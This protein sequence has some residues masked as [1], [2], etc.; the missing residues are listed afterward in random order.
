[1]AYC[2]NPN[3]PEPQNPLVANFCQACGT[4]L[5]LLD[6]HNTNRYQ[7]ISLLGQGGFG[8]TFLAERLSSDTNRATS[9]CT[10][11]Q[12]YNNSLAGEADFQTEAERLRKLGEHLQIPALLTAVENELGQ[13]LVQ[14]FVPGNNLAKQIEIDGPWT[15]TQVR[16]LLK[17]L[18]PILQ[19]VH[20]F[21]IIH[22]D[23]KPANIVLATDKNLLPMLVDF[24]AA[25]WVRKAPAKTVIGSAGYAAPE[26]SIGQATF[27]S[28]IYSLGLTC[29]HALTG[30]HP[31]ALYSAAEDRWVWRDYLPQPIEP[32]F[33]QLLDQ[34]VAPSLQQRYESMDQV[35][36]D[37]QFSRNPLLHAP[38]QLLTRAKQS[39]TPL[40]NAL[41]GQANA[42][43]ERPVIASAPQSWQRRHRLTQPIG[44]TQAIAI[45]PIRLAATDPIFATAGTDGAVRLWHLPSGQLIHTFHRR[46]LMGNGH[47]AEITAL[48]FHPDGRALYSACADGT[49]KEWDSAERCLLNTLPTVGWTPTALAITPGGDQLISPYS[50]GQIIL[51]DIATLRPV[52]Q[53]TQHQKSVN[54]IDI[55]ARGD[56]LASASDD[57][58]IKL[59]RYPRETGPR[60]AKTI[61]LKPHKDRKKGV[62]R[63]AL[64]GQTFRTPTFKGRLFGEQAI[65]QQGAIAIAL[66]TPSSPSKSSPSQQQLIAATTTGSVQCYTLDE[67]L[68][69]SEPTLFYQSPMPITA[70]ALSNDG[71]LAIGSEDSV[72]TLWNIATGECVAKLPHDWGLVAIAFSTDSQ[73]L[74]STS[75][76]EVISIWQRDPSVSLS[77]S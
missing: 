64:G 73:T 25:K 52:A 38:K 71:T 31:F 1:M 13:F 59:W 2:P 56:L 47:T 33:A 32:R 48:Q 41:Q 34:M 28:D 55:S 9:P 19:Y 8:R 23:I 26:Q 50:D 77:I 36:L 45:S 29:L 17:S 49:I 61:H 66:H 3:C 12:I 57:G 6:S 75:A 43:P 14:A 24:G 54:A 18:V 22:R 65:G 51:W 42:L 44:L 16:S 60:L 74:I 10:I 62:G 15:E 69:P 21:D 5:T 20:S 27:A 53:L 37:F 39:V 35:A 46:R 58:M 63:Q 4:S 68:T 30:M 11:K 76:D 40:T 72:L 7:L 70:F 67:Q